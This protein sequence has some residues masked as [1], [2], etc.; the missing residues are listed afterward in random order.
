MSALVITLAS[1]AAYFAVGWSLAKWD[2][3]RVWTA[4]RGEWSHDSSARESV[5]MCSL[6]TLAF[7][8]VRLPLVL[9]WR[10]I[11]HAVDRNDPSVVEADLRQQV[12]DRDRRITQLERELGIGGRR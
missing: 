5:V 2:M 1:I 6:L 4:A 11:S 7:W 8:P 12:D 3:P 9:L 10:S